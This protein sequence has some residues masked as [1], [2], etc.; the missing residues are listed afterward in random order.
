MTVSDGTL[1]VFSGPAGAGKDSVLIEYLKKKVPGVWKSVSYTT[2]APRDGEVDGVDY[3]FVSVDEF[4]KLI[5]QN[6]FLEYARYGVNYYG[7]P[8]SY[9]D[10]H[11][12]NGDIVILKI[13]VQGAEQIKQIYP[14]SIGA[15]IVPPSLEILEK[16]LRERGT[17]TD[18]D[19]LRR[20]NIAQDELAYS[21]NYD[22]HIINDRLEDAVDDLT[23]VIRALQLKK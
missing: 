16:R 14:H 22:Y 5:E 19:I 10:E 7:T 8:K 18:E 20:L 1:L 13:E 4:E 9:V 2:R 11:L 23:A 15:F 21:P 6:F 12:K 17:E 3:K